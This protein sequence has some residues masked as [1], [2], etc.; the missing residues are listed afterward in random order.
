MDNPFNL[1]AFISPLTDKQHA[2]LGRIALLWGQADYILDELIGVTL[3]LPKDLQAQ[4]IGEKPIGPKLDIIKPHLAKIEN[5]EARDCARTFY[6]LLNNTKTKRNHVFHG[7]WGWRPNERAKKVE[8]CAR[9]PKNLDNPVKVDD[10]SGLETALCQATNLGM[11]AVLLIKELPLTKGVIRCL[12]GKPEDPPEWFVQW[13]QQH[14]LADENLDRN[15]L[16]GQ[17]PWLVDPLK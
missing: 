14:P 12:H 7:V 2:Q 13:T 16:E 6:S 1:P 11:R 10:L 15:W 9:H 17:L 3:E 5:E 4:F 8:V